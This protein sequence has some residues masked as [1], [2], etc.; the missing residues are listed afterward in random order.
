MEVIG[1]RGRNLGCCTIKGCTDWPNTMLIL[2]LVDEHGLSILWA[3]QLDDYAKAEACLKNSV[4]AT[5]LEV[6]L[7]KLL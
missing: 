2:V 5:Q 3:V 4:G 7:F 6:F 1:V